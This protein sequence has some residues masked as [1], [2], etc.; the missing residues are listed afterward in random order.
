MFVTRKGRFKD[1]QDLLEYAAAEE[2]SIVTAGKGSL[3]YKIAERLCERIGPSFRH[4][5]LETDGGTG[6]LEAIYSGQADAE[7]LTQFEVISSPYI[8]P[9]VILTGGHSQD[10]LFADVLTIAE[11]GISLGIPGSSFCSIMAR[12][13]VPPH[14]LIRLE[15]LIDDAYHSKDFQSFQKNYALLGLYLPLAQGNG[16]FQDL[17]QAYSD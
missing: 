15:K 1:F 12:S 17:I 3:G 11:A 14:K 7:L 10:P 9:L 5:F 13:D 2:L 4:R 8:Q 16:F 6:E